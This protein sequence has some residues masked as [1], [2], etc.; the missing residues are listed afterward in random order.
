M[1]SLA[2][3]CRGR[4]TRRRWRGRA[5]TVSAAKAITN[6]GQHCIPVVGVH[7]LGVRRP[8]I[9]RREYAHNARG[10]GKTK[11]LRYTVLT[12]V[13]LHRMDLIVLRSRGPIW[14]KV[15]TVPC[16]VSRR[17]RRPSEHHRRCITVLREA[18]RQAW[19]T[20][21]WRDLHAPRGNGLGCLAITTAPRRHLRH[22][23]P[24][25]EQPLRE[26][27]C[28]TSITPRIRSFY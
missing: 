11:A 15:A 22:F 20:W 4:F 18:N 2:E 14:L 28:A 24:C 13:L 19:T 3:L 16:N 26:A 10:Q 21:R 23:F 1:L 17:H 12:P 6:W 5:G 9:V 8:L 25:T 7:L 27:R